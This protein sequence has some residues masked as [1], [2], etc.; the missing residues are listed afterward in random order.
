MK[1]KEFG[2]QRVGG[3]PG[4]SLGSASVT[5]IHC[6]CQLD[7]IIILIIALLFNFGQEHV[8]SVTLDVQKYASQR[9]RS[10]SLQIEV[11]NSPVG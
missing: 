8:P 5:A 7:L 3:V 2:P 6:H 10:N 11:V 1:M 4:A 9:N